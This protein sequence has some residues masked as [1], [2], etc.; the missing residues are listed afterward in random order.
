MA[1]LGVRSFAGM[2]PRMAPRLLAENKAQSA[3]N[4]RLLSGNLE[5][6]GANV[7]VAGVT[8]APLAQTIHHFDAATQSETN[9]WFSWAGDVDVVK[10]PIAN[11]LQER[12]YW[13]GD[14]VP[15]MTDTS[16]ALS[17]AG[18]YPRNSYSLGVPAPATEPM[19][20]VSGTPSTSSAIAETRLYLI[21]YVAALAEDEE[22]APS[23]ASVSARRE[24]SAP[25]KPSAPVDVLVGQSVNLLDIPTAPDG[26]YSVRTKCIYRSVTG[27]NGT[28][29]LFVAEIPVAQTTYSDTLAAEALGE[30]LP[31][32]TYDMPPAT[33]QGLVAMP[34]GVLAGFV[35]YDLYFSEPYKPHAWPAQYSMTCDH[36]IIGLAVFDSTLLVL[37]DGT[38]YLV[39]GSEPAYYSM[40]KSE[41]AQSCVS[42][43]SIVSGDGG[44]VFAS[45]DGLFLIGGGGAK[46]LTTAL[47][48]RLEWQALNPETLHGYIVEN[49][50]I[51]FHSGGG[52]ILALETGD[53]TT[54]DWTASAGFYD[55]RLDTLFLIVNGGLVKFD[56]GA[57]IPFVWKSKRFYSPRPLS[58]SAARVEAASYPLTMLTYADGVLVDTATVA[59]AE[60]FHLP[61]GFLANDWEFELR[62]SV[63]VYSAM[64]AQSMREL[65]NA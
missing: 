64:L 26:N 30:E 20:A 42:K 28:P 9:Y 44:A 38:P 61:G 39:S 24:E 52:F 8:L 63:D 51:G 4:V 10:S 58:M 21:T 47:L 17:G 27:S 14:G 48:T 5:A 54:L 50:Y 12:T 3:Q 37:T 32:L 43:R 57:A 45:P 62:G 22:S 29:Y 60:A 33:L 56:Q 25:S 11:D 53:L 31:S 41:L 16:I 65:A 19:V 15:K 18:K 13:T 40:V 49:Q 46:S 59:S 23:G 55:T 6:M 36:K 7:P 35:G 1:V 34:G 2:A